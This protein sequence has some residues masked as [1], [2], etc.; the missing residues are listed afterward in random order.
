MERVWI[1]SL[2]ANLKSA[3]RNLK[4]AILLGAM[5]FTPCLFAEAQQPKRIPRIAFLGGVMP[6]AVAARIDAFRQSFREL[7]YVE[8]KNIVIEYRY[9]EDN[10]TGS[11]RSQL[12]SCVS[13]L[14]SSSREVQDRLVLRRKRLRRSR[15]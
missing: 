5:L 2:D 4:S 8:G 6:G 3:I 1:D 9:A 15:S 13:T 14:T 12:N 10:S 11:P 7:G